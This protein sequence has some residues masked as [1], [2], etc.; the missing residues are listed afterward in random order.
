MSW[1]AAFCREA[2]CP[3]G[4]LYDQTGEGVLQQIQSFIHTYD[5]PMDELLVQDLTQYPVSTATSSLGQLTRYSDL[6]LVLLPPFAAI[7]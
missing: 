1:T 2:D 6:Q 5:L 7:G 4:K 3:E